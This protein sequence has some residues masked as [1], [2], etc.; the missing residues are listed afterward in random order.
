VRAVC[1]NASLLWKGPDAIF[2]GFYDG[3]NTHLSREIRPVGPLLPEVVQK[4]SLGTR[5]GMGNLGE[6]A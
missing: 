6:Y 3:E 5:K 2:S 4:P 1:T